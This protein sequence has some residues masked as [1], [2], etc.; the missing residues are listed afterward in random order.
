MTSENLEICLPVLALPTSRIFSRENHRGSASPP[1][2][3]VVRALRPNDTADGHEHTILLRVWSVHNLTQP[4]ARL[5]QENRARPYPKV[6]PDPSIYL[7]S[8]RIT[9]FGPAPYWKIVTVP[10]DRSSISANS[11]GAKAQF[12][13]T[14]DEAHNHTD[15]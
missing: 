14:N 12:R 10:G 3:L 1:P 11:E 6:A 13:H 2:G 5:Q 4:H 9:P 7:P 15:G 8:V